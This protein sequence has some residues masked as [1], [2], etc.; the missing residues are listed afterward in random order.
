MANNNHM[1]F[2]KISGTD[3]TVSRIALACKSPDQIQYVK[4]GRRMTKQMGEV[5]KSLTV[6]EAKGAP[7]VADSPEL[8]LFAEQ[9]ALRSRRWRRGPVRASRVGSHASVPTCHLTFQRRLRPDLCLTTS[10]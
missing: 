2:T 9:A 5:P 7:V 6:L 3:L 8:A 4:L 1:E 10:P